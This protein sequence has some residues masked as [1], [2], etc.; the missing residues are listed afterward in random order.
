M[1]ASFLSDDFR[2]A[3]RGGGFPGLQSPQS[4]QLAPWHAGVRTSGP[5]AEVASADAELWMVSAQLSDELRE[6]MLAH[7]DIARQVVTLG[8]ASRLSRVLAQAVVRVE[9]DG[10]AVRNG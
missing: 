6:E 2:D 1:L 10:K 4:A 8:T 9:E 3:R 7:P 5:L